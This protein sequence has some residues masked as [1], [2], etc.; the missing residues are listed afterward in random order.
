MAALLLDIEEAGILKL[1]EMPAR[2]RKHDARLL[3]E[4]GR[5]ER[6]AVHERR[7]H[8]GARRSSQQRSNGRDVRSVFHSLTLAEVSTRRKLLDVAVRESKEASMRTAAADTQAAGNARE[9]ALLAVLAIVWGA[10]YAF[11]RLGVATIPPVTLIAARTLIGGALLFAI[12]TSRGIAMPRDVAAWRR[13]M[14]Q[15][16]LNSVV[17]FTLIAWAEQTVEA[18]LATILCSTSPIFTFLMAFAITRH[19]PVTLTKL[20]GVVA[21]ICGI[22]VIVGVGALSGIGQALLADLALIPPTLCSV[23]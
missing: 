19:E 14:L 4:L 2:R 11:I 5:G 13:F 3:G 23:G 15:A 10:S 8:V 16:L 22:F 17:P 21:G 7:E 1:A 18:G 9:Y 6:L 12:L 20:F